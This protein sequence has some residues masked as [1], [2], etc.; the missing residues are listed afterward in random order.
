[1]T[2]Y[3]ERRCYVSD[4]FNSKHLRVHKISVDV[5]LLILCTGHSKGGEE[6]KKIITDIQIIL[7]VLIS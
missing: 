4:N 5:Q 2:L 6:I 3:L 1:M 7:D